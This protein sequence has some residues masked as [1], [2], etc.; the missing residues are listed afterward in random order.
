M[1]NVMQ[2]AGA[3]AAIPVRIVTGIRLVRTAMRHVQTAKRKVSAMTAGSARNARH[4]VRTAVRSVMNVMTDSAGHAMNAVTATEKRPVRNVL[5]AVQT[6]R[7]P[8]SVRIAISVLI[9]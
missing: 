3:A 5:A 6:V 8:L 1:R 9:V 2:T 7:R 4:S